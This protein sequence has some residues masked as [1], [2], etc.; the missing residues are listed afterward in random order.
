M[1]TITKI[2]VNCKIC[3]NPTLHSS[4]LINIFITFMLLHTII[5]VLQVYF[6]LKIKLCKFSYK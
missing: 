1:Q 2:N 5:I 4:T 6:S 3:R